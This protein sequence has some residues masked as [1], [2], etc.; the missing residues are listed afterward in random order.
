MRHFTQKED[1]LLGDSWEDEEL[2]RY[3]VVGFH[4][5]G[6]SVVCAVQVLECDH[7]GQ[8][9]EGMPGELEDYVFSEDLAG[10]D[11]F[12]A[13]WRLPHVWMHKI[14]IAGLHRAKRVMP[15]R[16]ALLRARVLA[17]RGTNESP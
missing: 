2:R 17:T 11:H 10:H 16:V 3:V 4:P 7:L 12:L 14:D 15:G 9:T 1:I 5:E 6:R 8:P 13:S